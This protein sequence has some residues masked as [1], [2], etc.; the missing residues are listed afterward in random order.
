MSAS[1]D[2]LCNVVTKLI[3][4]FVTGEYAIDIGTGVGGT[5]RIS[6]VRK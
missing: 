1:S 4:G 5:K 3:R 6:I 2:T